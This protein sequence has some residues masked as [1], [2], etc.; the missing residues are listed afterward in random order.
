MRW[1]PFWRYI[2]AAPRIA[3]SSDSV[4]PLVKTISLSPAFIAAA[5]W[6]RASSTAASASQPKTWLRDAALPNVS[7]K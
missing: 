3:R 6:W 2:R 4:A 7:V 1:F 5:T